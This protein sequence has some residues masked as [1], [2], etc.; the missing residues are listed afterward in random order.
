MLLN[1]NINKALLEKPDLLNRLYYSRILQ[2]DKS[3]Y[4]DFYYDEKLAR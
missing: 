1:R 4:Y 3:M 2:L